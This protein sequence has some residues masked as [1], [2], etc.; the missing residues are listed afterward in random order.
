MQ[1]LWQN[2][3]IVIVSWSCTLTWLFTATVS[4]LTATNTIATCR[5]T[6]SDRAFAVADPR[7]WNSLPPAVCSS[8]TLHTYF[9][10][11]FGMFLSRLS[12]FSLL[13]IFSSLSS[14]I[15]TVLCEMRLIIIIIQH[16]Q[17]KP[18]I[19]A[20]WTIILILTIVY[21]DYVQRSCSSLYCLL[22]FINR[23]TYITLHY[24]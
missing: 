11:M 16:L 15:Y 21:F 7:A 10:N 13:F 6:I 17:K 1:K 19:S 8:A 14:L 22:R 23:P 18:Q 24:K 9:V 12:L 3:I 2:D 5:S 4:V 20:F